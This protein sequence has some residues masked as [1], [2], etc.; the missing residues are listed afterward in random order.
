MINLDIY[1]GSDLSRYDKLDIT[2]ILI[3]NINLSQQKISLA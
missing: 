2:T 3:E 1:Y